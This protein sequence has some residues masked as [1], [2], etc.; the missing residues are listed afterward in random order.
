[1]PMQR[2]HHRDP[3]HHEV[4]AMLGDQ[5]QKLGGEL[6]LL[7][8]PNATVGLVWTFGMIRHDLDISDLPRFQILGKSGSR[9]EQLLPMEEAALDKKVFDQACRAV[10][11]CDDL[12]WIRTHVNEPALRYFDLA[13]Q[14]RMIAASEDGQGKNFG[15]TS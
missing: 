13:S 11:G 1:M 14:G 6:P 10:F 8:W 4:A 12:G 3:C 15:A 7:W 9:T 5:H 2:P